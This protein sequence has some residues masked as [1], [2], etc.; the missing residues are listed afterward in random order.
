M[1]EKKKRVPVDPVGESRW[2]KPEKG[3]LIGKFKIAKVIDISGVPYEKSGWAPDLG[4]RVEFE[5]KKD[6]PMIL[7]LHAWIE[8]GEVKGGDYC[9]VYQFISTA[10]GKTFDRYEDF[11]IPQDELDSVVGKEIY[12]LKYANDTYTDKNSGKERI[13]FQTWDYISKKGEEDLLEKFHKSLERGFP[14]DF[15][16]DLEDNYDN[17]EDASFDPSKFS[18]KKSEFD[19]VDDEVQ[20]TSI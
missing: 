15:N 17:D 5:Y 19:D 6:K 7:N 2:N 14:K 10:K 4:L 9:S 18:D 20:Q 16:P 13:S 11:T 1:A 12:I 3:I 8:D